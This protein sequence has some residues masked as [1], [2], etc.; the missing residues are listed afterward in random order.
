MAV[1]FSRKRLLAQTFDDENDHITK[2]TKFTWFIEDDYVDAFHEAA[3]GDEFAEIDDF[4]ELAVAIANYQ[5]ECDDKIGDEIGDEMDDEIGDE[6][7]D[8]KMDDVEYMDIIHK[9]EYI[10]ND[11][12]K[13]II[14]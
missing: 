1:A 10:L 4:A 6:T 5:M 12:S 8:D 14:W 7:S 9:E 2:Y 3:K 13:F 11:L